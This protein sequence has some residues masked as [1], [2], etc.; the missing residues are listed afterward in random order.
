LAD[1]TQLGF[2]STNAVLVEAGLGAIT[3]ADYMRGTVYPTP[4]RLAWHATGDTAAA[5]G[6]PL[7]AAFDRHYIALVSKTTA[8]L[9]PGIFNLVTALAAAGK[10]QVGLH[11]LP[12][13][14]LVT[15][16]CSGT[17]AGTVCWNGLLER[18]AGTAAGTVA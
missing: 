3:V 9:F 5:C 15:W 2:T 16:T 10:S 13:V 11:S 1:S 17:V 8:G 7:G 18:L 4:Q 14:K 12:G 6:V